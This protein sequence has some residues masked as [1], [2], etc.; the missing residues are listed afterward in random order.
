MIKGFLN[1]RHRTAFEL[2]RD[3]HRRGGA[4]AKCCGA[5]TRNGTACGMPPLKGHT[6]C[7]RHA[8]PHAARRHRDEQLHEL[9]AGRLDPA[10]FEKAEKRRAANRMR[11]LWKKDPWISGSTLALGSH[12]DA[13]RASLT[14]LGWRVEDIPPAVLDWA[15]WRFRRLQIDRQ[16]DTGWAEALVELR[17]QVARAGHPADEL[18]ADCGGGAAFFTPDRVSGYSRRTRLDIS[19]TRSEVSKQ[20]KARRS[21]PANAAD[22][23]ELLRRHR[24][25][26]ATVLALCASDEDRHVSRRAIGACWTRTRQRLPGR[27]G[28]TC[29]ASCRPRWSIMKR[30]LRLLRSPGGLRQSVRCDR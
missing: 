28:F 11:Q 16:Q 1:D 25:D 4:L 30:P 23:F 20:V 15:R 18:R 8:G 5:H 14:A 29:C 27:P 6:R 3:E 21:K 2:A 17:D 10:V 9:A 22:L 7:L 26:L 13:F 24:S 19:N 12:E